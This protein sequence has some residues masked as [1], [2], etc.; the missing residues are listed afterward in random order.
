MIASLLTCLY[1]VYVVLFCGIRM[2][3]KN[4][5][6]AI[7]TSSIWRLNYRD[8]WLIF[9]QHQM[10]NVTCWMWSLLRIN[11]LTLVIIM[12]R[13]AVHEYCWLL[14]NTTQFYTCSLLQLLYYSGADLGFDTCEGYSHP[15]PHLWFT[16]N[17]QLHPV[18][19]CKKASNC[20]HPPQLTPRC[21]MN[22]R[23][24]THTHPPLVDKMYPFKPPLMLIQVKKGVFAPLDHVV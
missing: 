23:T 6:I 11:F 17:L 13:T 14:I 12:L 16:T 19:A 18:E 22:A 2:L 9:V 10:Y 5:Y 3:W 1:S 24:R 21:H 7:Q 8:P 20:T 4:K 15:S